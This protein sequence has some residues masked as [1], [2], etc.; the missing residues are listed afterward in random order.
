MT[1]TPTVASK[2]PV[3]AGGLV[4]IAAMV[5]G[6]KALKAKHKRDAEK[7]AETE[8]ILKTPIDRI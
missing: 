1:I 5:I 8:R 2:I 6:P 3:I 4:A 7:A